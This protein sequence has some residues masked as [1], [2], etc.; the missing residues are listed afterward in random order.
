[1]LRRV[2]AASALVLLHPA[3]AASEPRVFTVA[4][5]SSQVIE[6]PPAN[7]IATDQ[8]LLGGRVV[9]DR[10]GGFLVLS[11]EVQRVD[12]SGRILRVAGSGRVF[13]PQDAARA[14]DG[15]LLLAGR[16]RVLRLTSAG[17]VRPLTRRGD[18]LIRGSA[19]TSIAALGDGGALV[20]DAGNDRVLRLDP[21]GSARVVAGTGRWGI[22]G[23]GGPATGA[24]LSDPQDVVALGDGSFAIADG[25]GSRIRLV[26]PRGTITSIAG[27]GRRRLGTCLAS[28]VPARQIR[29][30]NSGRI[31]AAPDGSLLVSSWH[32]V[33]RLEGG[34]LSSAL[35]CGVADQA[36]DRYAEARPA[37]A[38]AFRYVDDVALAA[39]GAPLIAEDDRVASVLEQGSARFGVALAPP[40]LTSLASGSVEVATT[41]AAQVSVEVL[42]GRPGPEPD[43]RARRSGREHR[44][45]RGDPV[46]GYASG[47]ARR[48][49]RGWARRGAPDARARRADHRRSC[50]AALQA[51]RADR[52]GLLRDRGRRPLPPSRTRHGRVP[53]PPARDR[54]PPRRPAGLPDGPAAQAG[55]NPVPARDR[56]PGRSADGALLRPSAAPGRSRPGRTAAGPRAARRS[57]SA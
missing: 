23:D 57:R 53:G 7:Q 31:A 27:G 2:V 46:D 54:R 45:A 37:T 20:A 52:H 47:Q 49:D 8:T 17:E 30:S 15:T 19:F 29:L 9:A 14:A 18:P 12:P 16:V 48:H 10:D 44:R 39:D 22:S 40:T 5:T 43:A 55:R 33:L 26:D 24:R 50:P 4:G 6:A 38:E 13:E 28:P 25:D 42:R 34:T 3:A 21:D 41:E 56:G 51:S 36:V 32:G 35:P 11:G 1:M